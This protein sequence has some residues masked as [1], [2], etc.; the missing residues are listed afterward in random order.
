MSI[1]KTAI[2]KPVTT[3]LIFVAVI[4]IGLF[5]LTKLPI[6]QFPEMEPPYVSVMCTYP[7]NTGSEIETNLTKM[8]ENSLN[9]VEGLDEMTSTSKDNI[10]LVTMKFQWGQN[11]D[12]VVNDVRS[13]LDMISDNLPDGA[14]KPIVFKF[15]TSMMPIL[16]YAVTADESYAGL[17]KILEDNVTNVLN[18]VDGIGNLSVVGVPERYVY[19]DVDQ[20]KIDAFGIS[21]EQVA[22]AV[23]SNNLDV[24]S[25]TVKMGREQYGLRVKSEFKESSEINNL[26]VTT[27]PQGKK[28]FVKDIA[29]VRD[30]IKD[31]FLDSKINS[32]EG[33]RLIIMKQTGGNTVQI[34]KDVKKMM[35]DIEKTLPPD[36][37]FEIIN[38]SSDNIQ[39][40]I[41]S[42]T[43]SVMYALIFVVMVVLFFL[44]QWRATLIIAICIPISLIVSFIYLLGADS[45]LNIISLSSLTVAIGMVVDDAIVVL[46]N[47][48]KHIQR[49]SS[50]R[51]AAIYATNEVWISVIAT[52]LVTCAVFVPL[53]MLTG[54]AG[55]LFKELGWIVTICVCTSTTVAISL[56]PMLSSKMLKARD[57]I[58]E[59][60]GRGTGRRHGKSLYERTVLAGLNWLDL[61]YSKLLAIALKHKVI[62][63]SAIVIFFLLS[64]IPV[65]MEKIGMDFMPRSDEGR[66]TVTFELQRGT[67]IEEAAKIGRRIEAEMMANNPELRIV[68]TTLGSNEDAGISALMSS[69]SN[70]KGQMYIRATKKWQRERT[71]FEIANAIRDQF[72]NTPEIV[73]YT[74]STSSGGGMSS[75][76][77][78]VEIY[79]YD[80]D[81][82]N[83]IAEELQ[84]KLKAVEGAKDVIISRE[85]DRAELQLIF[86]KE[87]IAALGLSTATLGSY[88]RNKINGYTA[89]YLKEDGDEYYIRVRLREE[90][91][92]SLDKINELTINTPT[93]TMVKV[94]EL[95]TIKEYWAP[96]QIDRKTRQRMNKVSVTPDDVSLT[97]LAESIQ[98]ILDKIETPSDVKVII[99]G[100]YEEQQESSKDMSLLFLLI[101]ILV[102]IVMASQFESLSKPFIIMMSIPF[103]ISGVIF[104][105]LITGTNLNMVGMLG[106]IMLAG[107]VVKNGIVLV[108]YINLMR[109]RDYELN[110]AIVLSGRSRLRPVL[111]TAATTILG[112][113][114]MAL[115]SG[116]GAEIWAPMGVVVIG[117]LIVSTVITLIIVPVLYA[118]FSKHGERDKKDEVRKNFVFYDMD[119]NAVFDSRKPIE[120]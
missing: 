29:V 118:I 26:V 101:I 1:Y 109:D 69:T 39:N 119:D 11:M 113:I 6:D 57:V 90:D 28:V 72:D 58:M 52:T 81:V 86:N 12:E 53:T 117:G 22:N 27:T 32:R 24:S 99:G 92:N 111:M 80:F 114:P 63:I 78:D 44:G 51:E 105:L 120:D 35:V 71:I 73:N 18:R 89:G 14:G 49:G 19:V 95:A 46:E 33:C 70:Y 8:L 115:S 103:A 55:I 43:E 61:Q 16:M 77:I 64:L 2:E 47:I 83:R 20:T 56:T 65:F 34:C 42:L 10:A 88:I 100:D 98:K 97:D 38:D 48:D 41:N 79:G 50:P 85:A 7:G 96:P 116:E 4:I 62:T 40:S 74:V 15:N 45:S 21:L 23:A 84:T 94:K 107:I 3:A 102:Y 37:K 9:S 108:D 67:R 36:V 25:G 5:A 31:L 104:A 60:L 66:M 68:S 106:V 30:T 87:K 82:T 54:V 76:S 59:K 93:G 110:E 13:A 91:R 75:N 17:E 112:M